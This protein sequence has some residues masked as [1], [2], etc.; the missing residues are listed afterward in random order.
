MTCMTTLT[1]A[2]PCQ[3]PPK[4]DYSNEPGVELHGEYGWRVFAFPLMRIEAKGDGC[5]VV[6]ADASENSDQAIIYP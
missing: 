2:C 3:I 4:Q 1:V 5:T 6:C